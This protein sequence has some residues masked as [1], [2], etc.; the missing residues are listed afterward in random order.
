MSGTDYS[1]YGWTK[2]YSDDYL[3]QDG[4]QEWQIREVRV[5]WPQSSNPSQ[6]SL[7]TGSG[8]AQQE[9]QSSAQGEFQSY[10]QE[11]Q[12]T[13]ENA[14]QSLSSQQ[15][16]RTLSHDSYIPVSITTSDLRQPSSTCSMVSQQDTNTP[17]VRPEWRGSGSPSLE[18]QSPGEPVTLSSLAWPPM[19]LV[20]GEAPYGQADHFPEGSKYSPVSKLKP[21]YCPND[22]NVAALWRGAITNEK[23]QEWVK[24]WDHVDFYRLVYITVVLRGDVTRH[25]DSL[26]DQYLLQNIAAI[27]NQASSGNANRPPGFEKVLSNRRSKITMG[28]LQQLFILL[29]DRTNP[30][31][32]EP[33]TISLHW[34]KDREWG[35]FSPKM[36][37][38]GVPEAILAHFRLTYAES[39]QNPRK[40]RWERGFLP[41]FQYQD[42]DGIWHLP[43]SAAAPSQPTTSY[44]SEVQ[45]RPSGSQ[46]YDQ[47]L[48][49]P[50]ERGSTSHRKGKGKHSAPSGSSQSHQSRSTHHK[51]K[52][53]QH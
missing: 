18:P 17:M 37:L 46:P 4:W 48:A 42:L 40:F 53:A 9:P 39:C 47:Q 3:L 44:H 24:R 15:S 5:W 36:V 34:A 49:V 7:A 21:A 45:S 33:L 2:E 20:P 8:D 43:M 32:G 23:E 35:T 28:D 30:C 38:N 11:S 1:T 52:K 25:H 50:Q 51:H 19:D 31:R 27:F 41:C 6:Y 26:N 29:N 22:D 12:S 13:L 16:F 10:S 14:P